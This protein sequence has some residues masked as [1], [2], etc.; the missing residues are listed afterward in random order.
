MATP[1]GGVP[2][3]VQDGVTGYLVAPDDSAAMASAI[4]KLLTVKPLAM[5]MGNAGKAT[6]MDYTSDKMVHRYF[7]LYEELAANGRR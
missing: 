7:S 6:A 5:S 1:V 4:L 2:E 3:I